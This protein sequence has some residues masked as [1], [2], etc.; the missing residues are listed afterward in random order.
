MQAALAQQC[1]PEAG[2]LTRTMKQQ[3]SPK[4]N[5][6]GTIWGP[7]A[8]CLM[9]VLAEPCSPEAGTLTSTVKPNFCQIRAFV[10][11]MLPDF[12]QVLA[13][14]YSPEAGTLTRTMKPRRAAILSHYAPQVAALT[15]QL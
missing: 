13:E 5:I 2:T 1:S 8:Y 15:D 14:P 3:P 10:N 12:L 4:S 11:Q 6:G 9:Q 7:K